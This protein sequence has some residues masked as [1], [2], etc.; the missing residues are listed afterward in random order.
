MGEK[1]YEEAKKRIRTQNRRKL[2]KELLSP[3][4]LEDNSFNLCYVF[5]FNVLGDPGYFADKTVDM[6][7]NVYALG[8][9]Y[10]IPEDQKKQFIKIINAGRLSVML[11]NEDYLPTNEQ[12]IMSE[13]VRQ[14]FP[15]LKIE[16]SKELYS[17]ANPFDLSLVFKK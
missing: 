2:E 3:T 7:T 6:L 10:M 5:L 13:K 16:E 8:G 1:H 11:D 9:S 12:L 14:M 17:E 15:Y 4:Y